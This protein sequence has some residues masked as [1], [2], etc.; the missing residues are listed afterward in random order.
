MIKYYSI[1]FLS[2]FMALSVN[3]RPDWAERGNGSDVISCGDLIGRSMLYDVYE[4][5][6]RYRLKPDF[7]GSYKGLL[8]PRGPEQT[9]ERALDIAQQLIDR[10]Q[11]LDPDRWQIYSAWLSNFKSEASFIENMELFDVP[12]TGIG[13]IPKYCE[14]KQ[15]VVQREPIFPQDRRYII[16]MDH[17][18][19]LDE[20]HAAAAIL[21]E[22]LYR[23]AFN[24]HPEVKSSEAVRYLNALIMSGEISK[25]TKD[26][27]YEILKFVF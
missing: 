7:P 2:L 15:L 6:K 11:T 9:L 12:D 16:A 26:Q 21:H 18:A 22:L 14:L 19:R 4:A 13:F 25:Y 23:E 3:A 10:L 5:D 24:R 27:Y 20:T 17:W 8:L 1:F